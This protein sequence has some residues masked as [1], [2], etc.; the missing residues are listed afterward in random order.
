MAAKIWTTWMWTVA[1]QYQSQVQNNTSLLHTSNWRFNHHVPLE[2]RRLMRV[3]HEHFMQQNSHLCIFLFRLTVIFIFTNQLHCKTSNV[4][5]HWYVQ[6][7]CIFIYFCWSITTVQV[8]DFFFG[9]VRWFC[10]KQYSK[11]NNYN[12]RDDVAWTHI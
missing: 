5:N 3:N 6:F 2:D 1:N 10:Y 8:K 11:I 12:F 9:N 7:S 4:I